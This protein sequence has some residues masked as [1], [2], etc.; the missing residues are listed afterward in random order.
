MMLSTILLLSIFQAPQ[1]LR[2]GRGIDHAFVVEAT[3]RVRHDED[4]WTIDSMTERGSTRMRVTSSYDRRDNLLEA[5]ATLT[6]G[7][8]QSAATVE[9]AAGKARVL[10]AGQP[11][12]EF[13]VPPGVIVTSAPDWS[14]IVLLCRRHD[15]KQV[16][17]QKFAGLWIHPT[18]PAQLLPFTVKRVGSDTI[19]HAGQRLEL[20]RLNIQIR[21]PTPYTA[22]VDAH[23]TLVKLTPGGLVREGYEKNTDGLR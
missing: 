17:A 19:E 13:A 11:P 12:Q 6:Q 16:G 5:R 10:R 21:G 3:V 1:E 8:R 7:E 20:Q 9:I 23:G 15:A 4:G 2:L 22:W 18:Q 14:D